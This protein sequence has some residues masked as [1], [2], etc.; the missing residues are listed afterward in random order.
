MF[1]YDIESQRLRT[2]FNPNHI[3]LLSD[4]CVIYLYESFSHSL[5]N[6]K[7]KAELHSVVDIVGIERCA[8]YSLLD[9]LSFQVRVAVVRIQYNE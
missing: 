5:A 1:A 6:G 8:Q 4:G 2:T 7:A 9:I 3:L